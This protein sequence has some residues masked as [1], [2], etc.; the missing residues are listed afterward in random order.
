MDTYFSGFKALRFLRQRYT[1]PRLPV[2][3]LLDGRLWHHL[4][5]VWVHVLQAYLCEG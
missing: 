4:F 3:T 5:T 2:V 1:K